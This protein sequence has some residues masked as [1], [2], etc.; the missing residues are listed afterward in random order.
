MKLKLLTFNWLIQ[1]NSK[2]TRYQWS[3]I[4]LRMFIL[5]YI[6]QGCLHV[7]PGKQHKQAD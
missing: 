4:N 7:G 3:Q 2:Y 6:T 1:P 5:C